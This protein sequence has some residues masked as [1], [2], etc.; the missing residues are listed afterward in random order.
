MS[1]GLSLDPYLQKLIDI[2]VD[3]NPNF[4]YVYMLDGTH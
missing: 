4:A 3:I 1:R 2:N